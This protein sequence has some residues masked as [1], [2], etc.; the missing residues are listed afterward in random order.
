MG[1]R[2]IAAQQTRCH[3]V[4]AAE[5]LISE[6]GFENVGVEE[7]ARRAGVAKGS[8]YTYFKRKEDVVA[9]IA[10]QE[11]FA[12]QQRAQNI[13]DVCGRIR[14]FLTESMRY[15]VDA[16][17]PICRQWLKNVVEPADVQGKN[18]LAFD[19][20][21]LRSALRDACARGELAADTPVDTLCAWI[22]SAYYGAVTIWA[23]T[24]GQTD[25]MQLLADYGD[26]ALP[27]LLAPYRT[28]A[29]GAKEHS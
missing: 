16:G 26:A 18:K 9:A 19:Q 15:I 8:F 28:S 17:L 22:A 29:P 3:L 10:Q 11:F 13:G 6:K 24:D 2:Q 4:L 1:K 21:V 7:I 12:V 23:I 5:A 14:V 27:A 25:P 20:N